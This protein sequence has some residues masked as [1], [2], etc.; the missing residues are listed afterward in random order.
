MWI[1]IYLLKFRLGVV[2][3]FC[4]LGGFTTELEKGNSGE[5]LIEREK[6][7]EERRRKGSEG[8]GRTAGTGPPMILSCRV[9]GLNSQVHLATVAGRPSRRWARSISQEL[10]QNSSRRAWRQL[11]RRPNVAMTC[12][13][14]SVCLRVGLVWLV[15]YIGYCSRWLNTGTNTR[16]EKYTTF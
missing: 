11:Y 1:K 2:P 12:G 9:K 4:Q 13:Y 5:G 16:R 15:V 7:K 6:E 10:V 14:P 8:K 3:Y